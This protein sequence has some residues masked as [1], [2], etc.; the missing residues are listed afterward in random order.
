MPGSYDLRL[1]SLSVFIS[2]LGAYA[3]VELAERIAAA[4]GRVWLWWVIGG[5]AASGL[6]TWSMHYTGMLSFSLPVPV[7]YDWPTVVISFL[8]AIVS[9]AVALFLVNSWNLRWGRAL[10]GSIFIGGGIRPCI[11]QVWRR[12]DSRGCAA[13][14]LHSPP[15]Q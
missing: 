12:C 2:M 1:V 5:A 9:A 7:L 11:T 8:P 14:L 15:F 13:I 4:R 3:A 6:G 10:A